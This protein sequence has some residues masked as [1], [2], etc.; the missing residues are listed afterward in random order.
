MD[1]GGSLRE[2]A[3]VSDHILYPHS[4]EFLSLTSLGVARSSAGAEWRRAAVSS[5]DDFADPSCDRQT[6]GHAG[7]FDPAQVYV[8]AV[9]PD[10]KVGRRP[11]WSPKLIPLTHLP[12]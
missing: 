5:F 2:A 7:R 3:K 8:P 10:Q 1:R 4:R 9:E 12:P 11:D 6:R